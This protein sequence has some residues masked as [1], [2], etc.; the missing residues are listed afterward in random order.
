MSAVQILPADAIEPGALIE[1]IEM[2]WPGS[3]V[4]AHGER[5]RPAELPGFVAMRDGRIVGHVAY[6]I[7]RHE[8][9]VVSLVAVPER[10][11]TGTALLDATLEV[12]R[13]AGCHRAWLTTTNDNVDALRF[14]QRRGFVF[15]AL[16]RGA[17]DELRQ[18][19]KPS[20]PRTGLHGIPMRDELDLERGL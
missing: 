1:F 10:A 5:M 2:A 15:A 4:V 13:T 7:A 20:L 11:G 19:L 16:R 3:F 12:A 14:Y 9:E 18:T 17:M 8:A 6:R